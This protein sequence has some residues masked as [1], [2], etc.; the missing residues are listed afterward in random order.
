MAQIDR[1]PAAELDATAVTT[2]PSGN[3]F[4]YDGGAALAQK[5]ILDR[6]GALDDDRQRHR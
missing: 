3:V 1:A 2:V 6:T 5:L 4:L